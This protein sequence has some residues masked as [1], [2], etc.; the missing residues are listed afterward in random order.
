VRFLLRDDQDRLLRWVLTQ[1]HGGAS[2]VPLPD[3]PGERFREAGLWSGL[4]ALI[5]TLAHERTVDLPL[6]WLPFAEEQR[7]EVA[8]RQERFAALL[9]RVL[10]AL[11]DAEVRAIPVKGAA[12]M[13]GDW[14]HAPARPMADIDILIDPAQRLAAS[15]ALRR[16]GL[17]QIGGNAWEDTFLG[18]GDGSTGRVD[19]ESA[20]HNGKVE[21]HPGWVERLHHYL[22]DDGGTVTSTAV[23]GTLAGAPCWIL[24][25]VAFASHVV[26]HLSACVIRSDA[27]AL[28]VLDSVLA[29]RALH[30][31]DQRAYAAL[32]EQLD[33]RLSAPGLWLVHAYQ[34][35]TIAENVMTTA[36]QRLPPAAQRRLSM[37][38]TS[39]VLRGIEGRT[40]IGWRLAFTR[41]SAE[42]LCVVRQAIVPPVEDQRPGQATGRMR[43]HASRIR[44][45]VLRARIR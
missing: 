7:R 3:L 6:D 34:P 24:S 15:V 37:T 4:T 16:L 29:L 14:P 36:L 22:I 41:T 30:G 21:L 12:F 45:R 42:R 43:F 31:E 9:P 8:R 5:A 2:A 20:D 35:D 13:A 11:H 44:Q 25:P 38:S 33:P 27:R 28:N 40:D 18:W 1:L 26:G 39:A 23:P 32:I 19:G 17:E 10:V